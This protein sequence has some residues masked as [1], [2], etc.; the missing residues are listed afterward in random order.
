[1]EKYIQDDL[2]RSYWLF[3]DTYYISNVSNS[4]QS[5]YDTLIIK[6]NS[7]CKNLNTISSIATD[8]SWDH[9][10]LYVDVINEMV[11]H[12]VIIQYIALKL[13]ESRDYA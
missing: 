9:K 3:W 1:M 12:S 11:P 2:M 13:Y 8:I 10:V 5:K 4:H 7:E 6:F